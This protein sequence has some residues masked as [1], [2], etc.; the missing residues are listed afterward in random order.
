M[1]R[2]YCSIPDRLLL[3][4]THML[5]KHASYRQAAY[6]LPLALS[7]IRAGWWG[8]ESIF[9]NQGA[10]QKQQESCPPKG[11]SDRVPGT[12]TLLFKEGVKLMHYSTS[13]LKILVLIK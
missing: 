5:R 9:R 13:Q 4:R 11:S 1:S 6:L 7:Q 12:V 10:C 3:V 2:N 8:R